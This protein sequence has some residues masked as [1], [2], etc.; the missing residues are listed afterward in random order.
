MSVRFSI[1]AWAAWAPGLTDQAA[2]LDWFAAPYAVLGDEM[3]ALSEMPAMMR[4]RVERLGRAALQVAYR[5]MQGA[6]PCPAVFASR[7]GD[8]QRSVA[9][10][11]QLALEGAMSPAA[12]S[13]SVHNAFAALFSIARQD[14]SNY[15][16]ISAGKE[17]AECAFIEAMGLLDEGAHEV[18]VVCYDEPLPEPVQQFERGP[19]FPRAFACRI[20]RDDAKGIAVTTQ[21]ADATAPVADDVPVTM[22]SDI[23]LLRFLVSAA[24]DYTRAVDDR[25]W[26]WT[27]P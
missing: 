24:P 6:A 18:L 19:S 15:S 27:R 7:Y 5:A 14:R 17:T 21:H 20:V 1:N 3:P 4:R 12:F 11:K 26:H 16:A 2:W 9:L 23:A 22:P 25:V 8:M 10:M 13:M